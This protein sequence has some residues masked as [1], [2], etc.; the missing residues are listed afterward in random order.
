[1]QIIHKEETK[2]S[3]SLLEVINLRTYFFTERGVVKALDDVNFEINRGEILGLVGESGCGKSVTALSILDLVKHPGAIVSGQLKL[4]GFDIL[5]DTN[6]LRRIYEKNGKQKIKINESAMKKHEN[7]MENVRGK[8]ISMIFQEPF[9]A[10]NPVMTIGQQMVNAIVAHNRLK[11]L[12]HI[13][14]LEN[15]RSSDIEALISVCRAYENKNESYSYVSEWCRENGLPDAIDEIYDLIESPFDKETV[16]GKISENI[17]ERRMR[18]S[19]SS[20]ESSI[21]YEEL[22]ERLFDRIVESISKGSDTSSNSNADHDFSIDTGKIKMDIFLLRL[23]NLISNRAINKKIRNQAWLMAV[24][25]LERVN[26]PD[27]RGVMNRYPHELSG[28][29]QQ[30]CLIAMALSADP[31]LLLADEPTTALDVT[32]QAQILK[33]LRD[34]NETRNLSIL[35]ITHDFAVV[36]SICNR[37]AVMYA[38]VIVEYGS[39]EDIFTNPKHPYTVGLMQSIPKI[40]TEEYS[41]HYRFETIPGTVPNLIFPPGGCRFHPRCKFKMEICESAKPEMTEIKQGHKVACFLYG[42]QGVIEDDRQ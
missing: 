6:K 22:K 20:V 13:M 16:I 18:G 2:E 32:T 27:A 3:S 34:I 35:F 38:G 29:M 41:E 26:M 31:E 25:L 8:K 17:V 39:V 19:V 1:M 36:A 14:N 9:L 42:D 28:G 7:F 15:L 5:Y 21:K 4:E 24:D 10:L 11:I 12:R 33:L 23:R 40:N 30:R 37:V